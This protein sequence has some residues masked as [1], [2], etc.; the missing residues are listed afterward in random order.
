[1]Q[2]ATLRNIYDHEGPFATVYLESRSPAED[3]EHQLALRWDELRNR[4]AQDGATDSALEQLDEAVRAPEPTEVHAT[5]KILV[6][7]S[8]GVIFDQAFDAS[9]GSGDQAYWQDEPE[10][11]DYLR[12]RER[13]VQMLVVIADQTGATI[14]QQIV[15]PS[16]QVEQRASQHIDG[17][18]AVSKPRENGLH[19]A[20][21]Q[22]HADEVVKQNLREVADHVRQ[23]VRDWRPDVVVLAGEVQGSSALRDELAEDQLPLVGIDKGGTVDEAA[24]AVLA[25]ELLELAQE[26]IDQRVQDNAERYEYGQA[27]NTALAGAESVAQAAEQGAVQ[28][29]LLEYD[30]PAAQEPAL[31]A[32]AV[33]IGADTELIDTEVDDGVA[34]LLRF[35]AAPVSG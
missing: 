32:A 33:R 9:Q 23:T 25:E 11:G 7:N 22:H 2:T 20:K 12:E 16:H 1:M 24:E 14:R 28:T 29:L 17:D 34:A 26:L 6:A 4:L 8:R 27:H 19:H 5:G 15:G 3:A 13:L 10:L 21:I 31:I 35:E 30:R 18:Y